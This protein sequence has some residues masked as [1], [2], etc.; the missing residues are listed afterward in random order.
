MRLAVLSD[1]HGNLVALEAALAALDAMG[2]A[3][4]VWVLGDLAAFGPR[5]VECI[6]RV[7]GLSEIYGKDN[8]SVISGN[9]DRYLV[10]GERMRT[11]PTEDEAAFAKLAAEWASRDAALNWAAAQLTFDDYSY[12][13]KLGHDL[14]VRADGAGYIVGYHAVPGND[15]AFLREDT[16]DE[17]AADY[18][19]DREG[20]IGVGAHTHA[21]M[22]RQVRGWRLI[23][24]GSIGQTFQPEWAGRAQWGLF[25]IENGVLDYQPQRTP[26]DVDAVI[27]DLTVVGY[28]VPDRLIAR[29]RPS[30]ESS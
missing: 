12:L 11:P 27:A 28:P 29:F 25:T 15:E 5:P 10:T 4:T 13:R 24:V 18:L 26:F 14:S 21:Q 2:G 22:D 20:Q 17:Q 3:D 7:Q 23:N 30:L 6:R 19:L 16:P 9:T 1:I 8:V